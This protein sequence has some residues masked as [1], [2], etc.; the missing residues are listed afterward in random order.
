MNSYYEICVYSNN[1]YCG[2]VNAPNDS[3]FADLKDKALF[4]I[5]KKAIDR[6][7][8]SAKVYKISETGPRIVMMEVSYQ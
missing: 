7:N 5:G 6:F 2:S 1:N 4:A 8:A 3:G